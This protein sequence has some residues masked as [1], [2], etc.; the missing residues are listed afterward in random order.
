MNYATDRVWIVEVLWDDASAWNATVGIG[1]NR[2]DG[3]RAMAD[4][5]SRNPCARFRLRRYDRRKGFYR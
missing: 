5:K 1:L 2:E 3:R 4:W